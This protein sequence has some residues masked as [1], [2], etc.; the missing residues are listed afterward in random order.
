MN[1]HF[2]G[3]LETKLHLKDFKEAFTNASKHK[4]RSEYWGKLWLPLTIQPDKTSLKELTFNEYTEFESQ[5]IGIS[6]IIIIRY[7]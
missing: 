4:D 3:F 1:C 5:G 6:A 7:K 2:K